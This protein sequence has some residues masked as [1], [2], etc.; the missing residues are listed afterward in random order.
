MEYSCCPEQVYLTQLPLCP[1]LRCLDLA[2]DVP[3]GDILGWS[4]LPSILNAVTSPDLETLAI[5]CKIIASDHLDIAPAL[6][7]VL[8]ILHSPSFAALRHLA[9]WGVSAGGELQRLEDSLAAVG[10]RAPMNHIPLSVAEQMFHFLWEMGFEA[11]ASCHTRWCHAYDVS[12]LH[13]WR[14]EERDLLVVSTCVQNASGKE[15]VQAVLLLPRV[16]GT[17]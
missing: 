9:I 16:R 3:R 11:R 15:Y 7:C 6:C 12:C 1:A 2:L 5:E 8:P 17:V 4:W 14:K 10:V 13:R